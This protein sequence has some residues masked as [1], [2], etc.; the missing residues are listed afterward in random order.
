[1]F[2]RSF[3]AYP[4]LNADGE[5]MGGCI[6]FL[7]TLRRIVSEV[8]PSAVYVAWESGGSQRRR[9]LYSGYKLQRKPAK[10]NRFYGDD[11]PDTEEN[12]QR[13]LITLLSMMRC[14]PAC[15]VYVPDCEGDDT[16]A[17][18]CRGPFRGT[19]K[20]IVSSDKDLYQLLDDNTRLYSLHKKTFVTPVDVLDEFRVTAENFAIAK[21]LCGD[22][23]DN[24]PGIKG[25]GFKTVAR[26]YPFLGTGGNVTL[27]DVFDFTH[28]HIDESKT[29]QRVVDGTEDIR[30]NWRLLFLDGSMLSATQSAKVDYVLAN[31]RPRS[32]KMGLIRLL[33]KEGI[34]D[35]DVDGFFYTF[36]GINDMQ[37]HAGKD[38]NG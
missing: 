7:K 4:Q 28:A 17:Y 35:F 23:S 16:I 2:V 18:L 6:G 29:Y 32:D 26:L 19:P 1:M 8:Q 5:Q 11:I 13:Q 9:A 20:V 33:V 15:Q 37:Y 38:N 30:R 27:Q 3:C 22:P 31:F 10:L 12:K 34:S 25:L 24:V 21:A 14:V 36:H